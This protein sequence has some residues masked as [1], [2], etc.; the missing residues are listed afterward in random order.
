MKYRIRRLLLVV[1]AIVVI[2]ALYNVARSHYYAERRQAN[3]ILAELKGISKI[4]L[5]AHEDI[6]EEVS[7]SRFA[8]DGHPDSVIVI[9]GLDE[10]HHEGGFSVGQIG[11]W[12]L[13]TFGRRHLG[14]YQ[15]ETGE[16]VES[17]YR[18]FHIQLGP[19]SPYRSLFPFE[20]VTLQDIVDHY[21]ELLVQLETWPREAAPG[22]VTLE[23]GTTQFFYVIEAVE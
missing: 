7:G 2:G 15:E 10:Y 8:V 12:Q 6:V 18:G 14:A 16:P 1:S 20:V 13:R 22:S 23:D 11:K 5:H 3:S 9:A 21:A 19:T 17:D 4:Q